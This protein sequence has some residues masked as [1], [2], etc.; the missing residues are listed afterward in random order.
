MERRQRSFRQL[1]GR[2]TIAWQ[3]PVSTDVECE[4]VR[5]EAISYLNRTSHVAVAEPDYL[6]Q[7]SALP[8]D[9]SFGSLWGMDNTGQNGGTS[10][11]DINAPEAWNTSTGTKHTIVAVV[12]TGV[13]YLHPDLAANMWHNPRETAGNGRDD[14]GNGYRDDVYGW[15]FINNTPSVMDDN[16][17]GTHVSG[18][19][20]AVGDNGIGVAGV[21]W[22]TQIMALKFL[23]KNGSGYLSNAVRA[24]NYAVANGAKVINASFGGGGYDSAMATAINNAKAHGVI[25]VA[26]AGNDGTNN[27]SRAEYPANY[28]G[29]NVVAVA[30][31]DRTDNLASFSNYGRST[32]DIAAPG[33]SIYSTLPNGRYGTYSGTSMAAPT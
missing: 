12:D 20:G 9:P 21:N 1:F 6:V 18:T 30:A 5:R 25:V 19:I 23:D 17:H 26:A 11:A 4:C 14:D 16:G 22:N 10:N 3:R 31:T 28:G 13:D 33:V 24:I 15:N 29:D 7:I 32:V 8:N 2:D 27:D